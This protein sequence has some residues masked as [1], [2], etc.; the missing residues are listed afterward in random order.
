MNWAIILAGGNGSRLQPLT[1]Q[2]T[3]DDRP[4]QFCPVLGRQ[5]LLAQTRARVER[6]VP[7]LRVVTVVTRAHEPYYRA[8]LAD[9][10]PWT[11]VEQPCARG[12]A[13]AIAYGL[14]RIEWFDP[15]ATVGIFPADHYYQNA[16][17][18]RQTVDASYRLAGISP[19]H[20]LLLGADAE[21]PETE[22][23][24][25]EPAA[26]VPNPSPVETY[27]VHRFWEKPGFQTAKRLLA[28]GCL[29]NTFVTVGQARAF[30]D[31]VR[32]A[33]PGFFDRFLSLTQRRS[34]NAE[35]SVSQAI[36]TSLPSVDFSGDVLA[37]R[38]DRLAVVRLSHSGWTDL[39]HP[40]R[41]Q[42]VLDGG[43]AAPAWSAAG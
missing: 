19:Q 14:S 27:R 2:M 38:P 34:A 4:K 25:I 35:E 3:G 1:R 33:V 12:T 24:W 9:A 5:T 29:W 20:V 10:H 22:Y 26:R 7:P 17:A 40:R 43:P 30:R 36:Y 41:V 16:D 23:G 32:Q 42:A 28:R 18:V 37:A 31:L 21:R 15:D 6:S 11:V 8:E 39:G 13:A